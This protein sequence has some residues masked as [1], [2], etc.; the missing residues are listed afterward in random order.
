M[1]T[2]LAR[3]QLVPIKHLTHKNWLKCEMRVSINQK[4]VDQ[5]A[6][7]KKKGSRF[8]P[9]VVFFD[10]DEIYW[11]GDGFHRIEA[12]AKNGKPTIECDVRPGTRKDAILFN[13]R[14]N[15]ESQGLPFQPGDMKKS[16]KILLTDP[17]FE[18]WTR[19]QIH[20]AVGCSYS[21][22]SV[23]AKAIGLPP[24]KTGRRPEIDNAEVVRRLAEG[25][26]Y[27]QVAAEMGVAERTIYRE[28]V[29]SHF[30]ECPHCKG[31]GRVL[32][33]N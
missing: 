8:P 5:Y 31:T 22:V 20:K 18:G 19:M 12:D 33:S 29:R 13:L 6:A 27:K 2:A 14:S 17:E 15:Q 30:E 9:P 21:L 23:V 26:S 4:K 24:C 25:A 11:T 7:E 28:E 16:I 32:K 10:E 3:F 1:K